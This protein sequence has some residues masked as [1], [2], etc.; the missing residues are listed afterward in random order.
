MH[1][2]QS[3]VTL[4]WEPRASIYVNNAKRFDPVD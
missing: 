4:D 2:F 3:A 1:L